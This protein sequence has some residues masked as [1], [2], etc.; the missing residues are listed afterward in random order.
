M[1][2]CRP[3]L[4]LCLAFVVSG[5]CLWAGA[6]AYPDYRAWRST[7]PAAC[8]VEEP[9]VPL[10]PPTDPELTNLPELPVLRLRGD[11]YQ[12][13]Y[14]YGRARSA[15]WHRGTS[16]M[17]RHACGL[18]RDYCP[19]KP[20]AKA[21]VR[22]GAAHVVQQFGRTTDPRADEFFPPEYRAYVQG[23]ADGA[24]V[25]VDRIQRLIAY[26]MLSDASCSGFVAFGPATDDGRLLQL[27]SLDWGAE[28]LSAAQE[29]VL[30][31]HEPPGRQRYL[32]IGFVGLVGSI[33][34]INEAGISLTE[35]G[36]GS[37]DKTMRGL[38]MPL[39][40]ER[41]LA[42][43][44]TL[45]EAVAIFR[46][47]PGT[48]GYN[49]IVGSAKERRAAVIEKTAH[50]IA[51]F[52]VG[53]HNYAG[54]PHYFGFAGFDARSA[55]AA[56]PYIR[57]VQDG[58]GGP[59][60]PV[61]HPAYEDRYK[62]QVDLFETWGRKVTLERAMEITEKVARGDN[63]QDVIYDFDRGA[64]YVYN[65]PWFKDGRADLSEDDERRLRAGA[66]SPARVDLRRI[67]PPR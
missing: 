7:P 6:C 39:L 22:Q 47:A 32:S 10:P 19:P 25:P 37:Y 61:G 8:Q 50:R 26:V 52:E 31:V 56:S 11:G 30:L 66:Q 4:R 36:A 48:G 18:V 35:I 21:V 45:D 16:T 34:G 67:F 46:E 5:L 1:S 65:R 33:S 41:V 15:A 44:G 40:L 24:G 53:A 62:Q 28:D 27:R 57:A 2:I 29:A 13:G 43:A 42:E 23:I 9:G 58:A 17:D 51:V 59:G 60:S 64:V 54:D 3:S 49:F 14:A 63:L 20:V 12:R 38:P 55:S